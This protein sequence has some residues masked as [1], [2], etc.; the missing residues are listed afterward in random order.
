[1]S[2]K[3]LI[4][5]A[6]G[7]IGFHTTA[8][9]CKEGYKVIGIDNINPSY[10]VELK[11]SRLKII[12]DKYNYSL[13]E[14]YENDLEDKNSLEEIIKKIPRGIR[15]PPPPQNGEPFPLQTTPL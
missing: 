2:D 11:K 4:T 5:G 12:S 10:S 9:L 7:F 3:V 14:F 8:R 1:M 6:A 15:Q 13:W